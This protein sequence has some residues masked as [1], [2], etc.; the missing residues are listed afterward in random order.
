[1]RY[2]GSCVLPRSYGT[3]FYLFQVPGRAGR[4]RYNVSINRTYCSSK[5][6]PQNKAV[7]TQEKS[8]AA[9][10]NVAELGKQWGQNSVRTM[11]TTVNYWWEKYQEFVGLNE[12]REA[13]SKVTE[14][15]NYRNIL[16]IQ[17]FVDT[18][19]SNVSS[20]IKAAVTACILLGK[21]YARCEDLIAF[22]HKRISEVRC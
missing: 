17:K 3:C 19:S 9:L 21:L 10:K 2:R 14:V 8:W 20:E 16:Y 13:Q 1:M 5:E 15:S 6:S 7:S 18:C 11:T 22:S 12:V 4:V